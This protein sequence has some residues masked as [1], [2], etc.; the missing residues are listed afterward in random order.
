LQALCREYNVDQ[1]K[2]GR[3]DMQPQYE[4]NSIHL[5][6]DKLQMHPLQ[7]LRRRMQ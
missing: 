1:Y 3:F 6:R 5:V 4:D 2:Y 7:A